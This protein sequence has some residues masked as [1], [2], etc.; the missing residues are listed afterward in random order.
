MK[1]PLRRLRSRRA[2]GP[3]AAPWPLIHTPL[4]R[5]VP[6]HRACHSSSKRPFAMSCQ[7][8]RLSRKR[9]F[10]CG[11]FIIPWASGGLF[12]TGEERLQRAKD[13]KEVCAE[14]GL[15]GWMGNHLCLSPKECVCLCWQT[16]SMTC[17]RMC[18]CVGGSGRIVLQ[19]LSLVCERKQLSAPAVV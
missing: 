17:G 12:C 1:A 5:L 6:L 11:E 2:P 4:L 14:W 8:S 16:D 9:V 13:W 10:R 3:S 15:C 18:E 7:S 19:R